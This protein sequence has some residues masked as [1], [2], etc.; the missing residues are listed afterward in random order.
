[1]F[2]A[3]PESAPAAMSAAVDAA[4]PGIGAGAVPFTLRLGVRFE[5]CAAAS[6]DVEADV[7]GT[8]ATLADGSVSV[9]AGDEAD[10]E[11]DEFNECA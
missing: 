10:E 7:G 11:A 8:V 9:A 2:G 3:A 6:D 4:A 5:A 1:V